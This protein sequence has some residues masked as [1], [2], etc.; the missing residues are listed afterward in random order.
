MIHRKLKYFITLIMVLSTSLLAENW[1][2]AANAG[3][4][5][6]LGDLSNWFKSGSEAQLTLSKVRDDNWTVGGTLIYTIFNQENLSGYAKNNLDLE[7]TTTALWVQG[8]YDFAAISLANFY[9]DIAGGPVYWK[10]IRGEVLANEELTIP[11]I[12]KKALD[13]W[14]MGFR[15]GFGSEIKFGKMGVNALVNYQ[16]ITGSLW[17]TMLEYIELEGVNGFQSLNF[18]LGLNYNF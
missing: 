11:Q 2:V 3:L 1:Q 16:F 8:K 10:G 4:S 9:F 14:N 5:Q 6:P 18:Q 17:P 13:E 7:L 12:S 15:F